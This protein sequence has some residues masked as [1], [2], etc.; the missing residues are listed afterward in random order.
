MES[1]QWF[2]A[3]EVG[4]VLRVAKL[5]DLGDFQ[6]ALASLDHAVAGECRDA[7]GRLGSMLKE[8]PLVMNDSLLPCAKPV[9]KAA[10]K[11]HILA[12][13]AAG[14]Y[15]ILKTL[16][17]YYCNLARFHDIAWTGQL[18]FNGPDDLLRQKLPEQVL[19]ERAS[20]CSLALKEVANNIQSHSQEIAVLF[21]SL[22]HFFASITGRGGTN[23]AGD[24]GGRGSE[25]VQ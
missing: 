10:I 11:V 24:G 16:T 25:T 19:E 6:T 8:A 12:C 4:S 5:I 22:E 3:S 14:Q 15:E 13:V 23:L 21:S 2:L 17:M 1:E 9:M 18:T 7:V 20:R